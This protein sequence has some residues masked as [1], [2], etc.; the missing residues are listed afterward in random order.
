MAKIKHNL[1]FTG[2]LGMVSAFTM[3]GVEGIVLRRKGGPSKQQIKSSPRFERTRE[4]YIEFSGCP[5][6]ASNIKNCLMALKQVADHNLSGSFT[7]IA[8][9]ARLA[10]TVSDR[11]KRN[12]YLSRTRH[13][14]EGYELN[15]KKLFNSIVRLSPVYTLSRNDGKARIII[16]PMIPRIHLLLPWNEPVFR[17]IITLGVLPDM[18]FTENG[19]KPS[20][21][22]VVNQNVSLTTE[23]FPALSAYEGQTLSLDLPE[24]VSLHENC[25]LVLAIGIEAGTIGRSNILEPV[26]YTGCGKIG[27]VV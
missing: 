1:A 25:S 17:F 21:G 13:L 5:R 18:I 20:N 19:Y 23:W 16:P 22:I 9:T 15:R 3:R 7:R 14:L 10:D 24:F 8:M 27:M 26:K 6:A 2:T 4:N 12:I 11:G